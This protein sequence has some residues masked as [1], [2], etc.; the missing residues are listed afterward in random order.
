MFV[1]WV[2]GRALLERIFS[3]TQGDAVS[4]EVNIAS[5]QLNLMTVEN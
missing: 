1:E 4:E 2:G 5:K 3:S